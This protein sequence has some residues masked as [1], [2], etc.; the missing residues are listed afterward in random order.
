GLRLLKVT[1][2]SSFHLDRLKTLCSYSFAEVL[3]VE[4]C[5]NSTLELSLKSEQLV[6]H[7]A[8]ARAIKAMVEE[9]LSELKKNSGYVIALRSYITDDHSLLSFHRGDLIKLLPVATLEPGWQFGSAGGRSG[10]FPAD[11]VQP[12]AAPDFSFS[13]GQR[14]S[15]QRK[16][17]PGP[18][19]EVRKTEV[20]A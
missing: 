1:K 20:K 16:S 9:F 18:A 5:S 12:A 10:L 15:W 7:T 11:M 14:N 19:Q 2:D 13:L 6:L 17:K 8:R 4:C 3:G